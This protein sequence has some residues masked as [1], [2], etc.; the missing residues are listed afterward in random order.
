[1][2]KILFYQHGRKMKH[3]INYKLKFIEF[4]TLKDMF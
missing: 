4:Q 3:K 1:M 2:V